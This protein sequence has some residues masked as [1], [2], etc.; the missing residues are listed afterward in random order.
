MSDADTENTNENIV[1]ECLLE[2]PPEKVWRALTVPEL[3]AG[4]LGEP[5][6]GGG[7]PAYEILDTEPCSRVRYTWRDEE[8]DVPDTL[9]TFEISP[10]PDGNTWFRLTHSHCAMPR[11]A[12]NSNGAPTARA[13]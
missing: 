6:D 8:T 2:S 9:V 3:A 4:W 1:L 11:L 5:G 13:A 12:A 10:A 7:E